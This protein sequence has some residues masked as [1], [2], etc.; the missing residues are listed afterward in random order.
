MK[1]LIAIL[2]LCFA[3]LTFAQSSIA[4]PAPREHRG[5][6]SN[7]SFGLN[8][9][10][11]DNSMEDINEYDDRTERSIDFY[12]YYGFSFLHSEF[13]F[14]YA[15]GNVVAFHLVFNMGIYLGTVDY[16]EEN[17]T[18]TCT[19]DG[20]CHEVRDLGRD[21]IPS[22]SDGYNFRTY[23]GFG[24]TFYPFRDKNSPLNGFFFGGSFGYTLFVMASS[25]AT[26]NGGIGFQLELGKEWWVSDHFSIGLGLG[27]AHNGLVWKTVD[28][29][30]SDNV[31]SLSFR[32]TRG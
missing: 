16:H 25:D 1:K 2:V 5:F 7:A 4:T 24:S 26:G 21:E 17:F 3:G 32:L 22:S 13:K 8:L 20:F 10:L 12:E 30:R 11:F 23:I 14:G 28:S 27:F 15:L 9:N 18:T 6:Y 19:K 29:H 31:L